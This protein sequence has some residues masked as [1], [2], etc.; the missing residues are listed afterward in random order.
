M[1]SEY[2]K[3]NHSFKSTGDEELLV[4]KKFN[5]IID[6]APDVIVPSSKVKK[7]QIP[8]TVDDGPRG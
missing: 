5:S 1:T 4:I 3:P 7:T 2:G 6:I 8:K